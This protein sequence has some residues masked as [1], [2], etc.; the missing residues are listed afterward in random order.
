MVLLWNFLRLEIVKLAMKTLSMSTK[1]T[2]WYQRVQSTLMYCNF[3]NDVEPSG[4]YPNCLNIHRFQPSA[5]DPKGP[6]VD[7][8]SLCSD[9]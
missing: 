3:P 4:R 2:K 1:M 9:C 6:V 8:H 7:W 5:D